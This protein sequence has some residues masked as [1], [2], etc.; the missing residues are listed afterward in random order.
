MAKDFSVAG[1]KTRYRFRC[2]TCGRKNKWSTDYEVEKAA[3][4]KHRDDNPTHDADVEVHQS[5]F[6]ALNKKEKGRG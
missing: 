2:L 4:R 3:A 1:R 6:A 5:F